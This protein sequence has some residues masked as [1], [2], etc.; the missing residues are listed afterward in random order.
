MLAASRAVFD[1]WAC[2][3]AH[4][5]I[6][7]PP[8]TPTSRTRI[9]MRTMLTDPTRQRNR[10]CDSTGCQLARR[11]SMDVRTSIDVVR[12]YPERYPACAHRISARAG[13]TERS[14]QESNLGPFA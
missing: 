8:T 1:G 6:S 4:A 11:A 3:V 7:R 10:P 5:A 13:G 12:R 9:A 14:H 2:R